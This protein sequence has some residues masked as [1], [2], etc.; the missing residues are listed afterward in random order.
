MELYESIQFYPWN[1]HNHQINSDQFYTKCSIPDFL[2]DTAERTL[3]QTFLSQQGI[4]L[5]NSI[6]IIIQML[7]CNHQCL[8]GQ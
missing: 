4:Y 3:Y 6:S 1:V 2:I 7:Y 5:C 8:K